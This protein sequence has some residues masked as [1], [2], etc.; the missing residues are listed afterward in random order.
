[1]SRTD[2]LSHVGLAVAMAAAAGVLLWAGRGFVF[3]N[4][5]LGWFASAPPDYDPG[6]LVRPHVSHLM[7]V[8]RAIYT[9]SL[10]LFGPSHVPLRVVG[11]VGVLVC[12]GLFFVLARRRIGAVALL[13][14]IV[15]LFLGSSWNTLVS[16][17]GIPFLSAIAFGLAALVSLERNDRGG[18]IG[19]CVLATLAVASHSFALPFLVGVAASVLL[20]EDRVR[21]AWV[22]GIPLGLYVLWWVFVALPSETRKS[23]VDASN[24]IELPLFAFRSLGVLV[25]SLSGLNLDV[26]SSP[27]PGFNR[28]PTEE[29]ALVPVLALT[30][31]VLFVL[32]LR[33]S[34]RPSRTLWVF[35][36]MLLAFWLSV[37]LTAGP[38]RG[39][40]TDRYIFPGSVILLLVAVEAA[41]GVRFSR[42]VLVLLAALTGLSVVVN[43]T[44]IRD[45]RAFLTAYSVNARATLAMVELG[46]SNIRP[47][48]RPGRE[49]PRASPVHIGLTAKG[50]LRGVSTWGSPAATLGEVRRMPPVVRDRAD[51]VLARGLGLGLS[52]ATS[53]LP[54]GPCRTAATSTEL[55]KGGALVENVGSLPAEVSVGRFGPSHKAAVGVI[56]GSA[57]P[58]LSIPPDPAPEPWRLSVSSG[59]LRICKLAKG[60]AA[61]AR[62]C[63]IRQELRKASGRVGGP[64]R[65]RDGGRGAAGPP[66]KGDLRAL[67]REL[68]QVAPAEVTDDLATV[69]RRL[70]GAAIS[71]DDA[72]AAE[73]RIRAFERRNCG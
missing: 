72:R 50:Y 73:A 29:W 33:R 44:H 66:G 56:G 17:I 67:V 30:G 61:T 26:G 21:R 31:V 18:D 8:G 36:A 7:V 14:T 4:D 63:A 35:L 49:A 53:D 57:T 43:L 51:V 45:A 62:F 28:P 16:P 32:L 42:G 5:E 65:A 23:I 19:A 3:Y 11:V 40:T 12:A 48:F 47:G 41:R 37:G 52:S 6:A 38:G 2:R 58:V 68:R 71:G 64:G 39:P 70:G 34:G 54:R 46:A 9:T 22:F 1:M 60:T 25:A 69:L 10:H 24:V 55:P 20:R 13:P 59:P 27:Q 15:L